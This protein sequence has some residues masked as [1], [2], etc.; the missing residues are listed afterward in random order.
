MLTRCSHGAWRLFLIVIFN[1]LVLAGGVDRTAAQDCNNNGISDNCD[2][3]CGAMGE[4]CDVP[5]CGGSEDTN[6]NG[7][8]DECEFSMVVDRVKPCGRF[9][10]VPSLATDA[11]RGFDRSVSHAGVFLAGQ[12][13]QSRGTLSFDAD[14]NLLI[15]QLDQDN[16]LV[17]S[18]DG[19]LV[20]TIAGGGLNGPHGATMTPSGDIA[21]C[22]FFTD[23]IKFFQ[24]DGVFLSDLS[25]NVQ[26]PHCL[27]YDRSGNLYVGNR[28]NGNGNIAIFDDQLQFVQNIAIGLFNPHP[29]DM[30]FDKAEKLYVTTPG[31]ILKFNC[32]GVLL[33]IIT[34]AGMDPVGIAKIGRA[35]CRERV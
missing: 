28:N 1:L 12:V 13:N 35:S 22:S 18:P 14:G 5:G 16:I 31:Y 2:L 26:D 30:A 27:A 29:L 15:G 17:V 32:E 9:F 6:S 3:D 23:S 11:L 19:T 10:L 7:I 21:V 25:P 8:P 24:T 34:E 33:G 4:P 20:R